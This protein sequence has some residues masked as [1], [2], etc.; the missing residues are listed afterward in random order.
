MRK[1]ILFLAAN[2]AGTAALKL[3]EEARAIQ[4]EIQRASQRDQFEFVTRMAARP[5]DLLRALRDVKPAIVHF[6][7][8]AG[9]DGIYLTSEEGLL[10]GVSRE[11]LLA[12][13][14]AAGQSVQTVVLNGCSTES[15]AEAL[16][17]FVPI[18]VGTSAAIGDDAARVFSIGFYG[19]LA[20]NESAAR[21]CLH[22]NAAM[23][24]AA[25]DH[26]ERPHLRHRRDIDP[27]TL[28]LAD[29]QGPSVPHPPAIHVVSQSSAAISAQCAVTAPAT[30]AGIRNVDGTDLIAPLVVLQLSDLHFGPHSRFAG[31][32]L[33]HL[34]AQCRLAFDE[35]RDALGWREAVGLVLVTGDITESARPREYADA[36]TFF[37]ALA[38]QL[39]LPPHRFVFVPG[40]HDISWTK[41]REVE[42]QLE[43]GAFPASDLRARLDEVKLAH[44]E[45]FIRDVHGGKARH[46][47]DGAAVTSLAHGV[48][49]HDF[50]DLGISVA[51]L[52]SCERESH[53]KA[54]H[55]GA[56]S[57][58][59]AQAVLDHWRTSSAGLIRL[60]V[61]H[62]N[63]AAM[64]STAIDQWLGFLRGP[65]AGLPA[66]V[67]ERIATNFVGLEGREH[68]RS[69]VSDAHAS[70]IC[71]G[72]HHG[73]ATGQAWP[74]R[75]RDPGVDGGARILSA[76]SWGLDPEPGKLPK[77]QPAVMPLIRLD[78]AAAQLHT[79]LLTYDPTAR[80][81]GEVS[82]GS[83]LLDAQRQFDRPVGL[84]L[85]PA[86]RG[87]F[88]SG[89]VGDSASAMSASS[90]S[91]LYVSEVTAVIANYR[92]R[93]TGSFERWD[94]RTAGPVPTT[95]NRPAEITLDEMY[96]PLRFAK[97]LDPA[98]LDRGVPIT[99]DDLRRPRRPQVVIGGAG[100]GK[101]TWMR[102]TFRRLILH[103]D[104]V[105]FFL[106]LRTLATGWKTSQDAAR[107]IGS[108]LAGELT[109]CGAS[110]PSAIVAALLADR[111]GP[112]PV[113]LI[114]GWDEL[115]A[116]GERLRERLVEFCHAFPRVVVLVSS[117]PYGETR[118]TGAEAFETLQIQPLS[119]DDVQ[120]LTTRFH[121]IV[122]GN[123]EAAGVR[124]TDEFMTALATAPDARSLA[125]TALLLTMMLLLS[126]EG[127][128]PD[129]RHKLYTACL[130]NM[131]L[132]RVAQRE[133]DGA[134]IDLDQQWR[135]DDSEERLR[136]VAEMAYRMQTEGYEKARRAL[137]V[138]TWNDAV[139]L[140]GGE[141]TADQRE[142][143]LRWLVATAGVLIERT[144]GSVQ[145]AHLSFQE[146]LAAYYLFIAREGDGRIAAVRS[147]MGDR[148]WWETLRLWAGL[149]G[150]KWPDN[151]SPV[152][153]VLRAGADTYW[154][155]GQIFADGTGRSSDFDAWV[156]ELPARLSDPFTSGEDCASVWVACKQEERRRRIA[157]TLA[158]AGKNL[159][160]LDGTWHAHWC[161]LANLEVDSAPSLLAL[162]T[163]T[164]SAGAVARSRVMFGGAASWPDGRGL[165]VLRL[166]PSVRAAV[167]VRLQTAISLGAQRSEI[168]AMLPPVL[169]RVTRRW[170]E[171]DHTLW[172]NFDRDFVRYFGRDFVR[173]F[174]QALG[175]D[176]VR[177]FVRY[178]GRDFV[179]YF[180][181]YFVRYFYPDV[182]QDFGRDLAKYFGRDLGR[183][184][185][186]Y[187]GRYF[188]RDFVRYFGREF[189]RDF[190]RDFAHSEHVLGAPW[191]PTFAFLE[192]LARHPEQRE[193][194]LSWGLQ[195][196]VRGDLVWSDD[197]V[198]TLDELCDHAGLA[199]LPFLEAMPD[200]L[201]TLLSDACGQPR[202][203]GDRNFDYT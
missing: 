145:F 156:A 72:H 154:L 60:A 54:D 5:L 183:D 184:F 104:A 197:S 18:C 103:P 7:G 134:A 12:T 38:R 83:F 121:R 51:A 4:E 170:S 2:P 43:D 44:F 117:R 176:F 48:F 195:H 98:R 148:G 182:T 35:A 161:G 141:W 120:L 3:D 22:G 138:R 108:Y 65:G 112:Q 202:R 105:P 181:R 179:G 118:P 140:F 167:G 58:T 73:R 102:W 163:R 165:A 111:S 178:F 129:R 126:R 33:E 1:Q 97:E 66:D 194:P 136:V 52:N 94:L 74:W 127:P 13:F 199:P 55:V 128:L 79:V 90:Q 153:D 71:H 152:L 40:N 14:G 175:R 180:G 99:P 23:R 25:T 78:P 172:S 26:R 101:T 32:D 149:I 174:G 164:D 27:A 29:D 177:Y 100:S 116:Q 160:W 63:P 85:P 42:G 8:H 31:C 9:T 20:S 109:E 190:S 122:H 61:V 191:L 77:D 203:S 113:V 28:I 135:P 123:D 69:M 158:S 166:W 34:A 125:G 137:M 131:L 30:A 143:F 89:I 155:A 24:L 201:D 87:R 150:D 53:R 95:N 168:V 186:R 86:L 92:A 169:A 173:D 39:A 70:L 192:E 130:R 75:G 45:K 96:I 157:R 81:P 200:E 82:P 56:L 151:L 196:Y 67:V 171:E 142:R 93:K 124:A 21:A 119:D 16:C 88:R 68:L 37:I 64:T 133:R 19:A 41:C 91:E 193:S 147:H 115:G 84:S 107:P 49:L 110:D 57:A 162:E 47:V 114:D 185:V 59:Q 146:H 187:F 80:L 62:H 159:H 144:D 198:V 15:L 132:H 46:E 188:V 36:A 11:T 17:E 106:E 76:G 10:A 6:A 189:V 50:A 139:G